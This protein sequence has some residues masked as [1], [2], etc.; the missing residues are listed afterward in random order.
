[1]G[2]P[3]DIVTGVTV[4]LMVAVLATG[5]WAP[6]IIMMG[7]LLVLLLFGVLEPGEAIAGFANE[8]VVTVGM[9]YIMATGLKETGAMNAITDRLLGRPRTERQA[10]VRLTLPVVGMSAFVNNTPIVAMFLPTLANVARRARISPS[11]LYMPLS[12]ASILGGVC[13]LIGTSTN[14]LI[15]KM[16]REQGMT[17]ADG[18]PIGFGMFTLAKVGLPI[19]A[20]GIAYI[21]L[22]GRRMLPDRGNPVDDVVDDQSAYHATLRVEAGCP[23]VGKNVEAADLRNLPGVFLSRIERG[24]EV[25]L[26]VSPKEI[27]QEGD[28]LVFVGEVASVVELQQI[29]GL[30]PAGNSDKDPSYRPNLRLTEAVISTNSTLAGSTI[31]QSGIRTRYG[32]VVIAVRRQ[33]QRLHGKLG[34]IR[35]RPGDTLLMEAPRGFADRVARSQE[36]YLANELGKPAALRHERAWVAMG[37]LGLLVALISFSILPIMVAAML[38]AGLMVLTR[39]CT[40]PQARRGVDFQILVV[41]GAAFGIAAA[42][43]KTGLAESIGHTIV[44]AGGSFGPWAL[45]ASIYF[46]T[47]VFTACMT[48]NAAAVLMFP[49]AVAVATEQGLNPLP[50]VVGVAI[51][52]S[53]EF[54]TPIG[55][56]TNL[57]VMGPG[58]YKWLDYTKFGGPLTILC[59]VLC[60]VL[61]P[62]MFG[63]F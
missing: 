18:E 29:R 8:G 9:L 31:R 58:G 32:A 22:F 12:F 23:I 17:D 54:S 40:G 47:V 7:V 53:C 1:M 3:H 36:F 2:I 5:R 25:I 63:G 46:M 59:G 35:L 41:I 6:D 38:A 10:Q 49:I 56:Q 51:A 48:N 57:M 24:D 26:A 37:I 39:C 19:A 52:A 55:Y 4:L 33:G 11:K 50:F 15:D 20:C 44:T 14:I 42:M 34:D 16:V 30:V 45:L 28:E 61:A 13:T 62:I 43:S 60:V 21:L 27:I